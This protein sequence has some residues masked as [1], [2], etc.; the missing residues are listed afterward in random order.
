MASRGKTE[1]RKTRHGQAHRPNLTRFYRGTLA[2]ITPGE[3]SF[4]LDMLRPGRKPVELDP[5]VESFEWVD[6]EA[7]LTGTLSLAQHDPAE[8]VPIGRGFTVRCRVRW[9]RG[10]YEV[11]RMRAGRPESDPIGATVTLPLTDDLD[12]LDRNRRDWRFRKTHARGRGWR[13]DEIA[14]VVCRR[15]HVRVRHLARGTKRLRKLARDH[16]SGLQVIKAAYAAEREE[17]GR[18]F[19]IRMRGGRLEVTPFQRNRVLYVLRGQIETALLSSEGSDRPVSVIEA[20]G[21]TQKGK[22]GKVKVTVGSRSVARRFGRVVQEKDYGRV[23]SAAHLRAKA[24]RD[25]AKAIRLRRTANLTFPGI[26]FIRRGDG[27]RWVNTEPG[28]HGPS[29]DSRDRTYVYVT[30]VRNQVGASGEYTTDLDV[31]QV[32]PFVKD[33]ERRE[34][35]LRA[36]RRKAAKKA[37]KK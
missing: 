12:A 8:P 33:R 1:R 18:A 2:D 23:D 9:G 26:P 32:D 17:S 7:Q 20:T 24:R 29:A 4:R 25:L 31:S 28:W 35:E 13:A 5:Y 21:H 37:V 10:W 11:W 30:A 27:M 36:K 22:K 14:A 19:I 15:E 16:T 6:E 34:K 3:F